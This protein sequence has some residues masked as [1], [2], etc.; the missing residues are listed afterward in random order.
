[1]PWQERT[2]VEA[3]GASDLVYVVGTEVPPPG[4]A[5]ESIVNLQVTPSHAVKQTVAAHQ[6]PS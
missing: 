3:F 5:T 4:G 2:A 6:R 1:M